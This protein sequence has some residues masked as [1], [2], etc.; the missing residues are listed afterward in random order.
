MRK[1]SIIGAGRLGTS[2]GSALA[3]QD[4]KITAIADRIL[5]QARESSMIIGQGKACRDSALA[6]KQGEIIFLCVPDEEIRKVARELGRSGLDWRGKI[7]FHSSGLLSSEILGPLKAGGASVASF[8][9]IQ[10]FSQKKTQAS[11]FKGIYIGLE[12]DKQALSLAK[13]I[14]STLGSRA[15]LLHPEHKPLYHAA[16][17]I[18]SNFL[19]ILLDIA[20]RLFKQIGFKEEKAL[21]VLLPLVEGTLHNV[22][23]FNIDASLTGPIIRGDTKSVEQHLKALKKFPLLHEIYSKLGSQALLTAKRRKLSSRKIKALKKLLE[24]K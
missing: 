13:K 1:V 10:S 23:Q 12:G 16:C 20:W 15:L 24:G 3:R 8:H 4:Y 17:S 22:K 11:V 9:P 6:A 19:V 7:F 18:A 21:S 5:A 2:L 14:V